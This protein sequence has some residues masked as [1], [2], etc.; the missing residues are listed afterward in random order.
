MS[1]AVEVRGDPND[2]RALPH[3]AERRHGIFRYRDDDNTASVQ[4][5]QRTVGEPMP[6]RTA[7]PGN[8]KPALA[9]DGTKNATRY[10][11]ELIVEVASARGNAGWKLKSGI[12]RK[13]PPCGGNDEVLAARIRAGNDNEKSLYLAAPTHNGGHNITLIWH[14]APCPPA[15]TTGATQNVRSSG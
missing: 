6:L 5:Q 1:N 12:L 8:R 15:P 4:C 11:H 9:F 2:D 7:L 10:R 14:S 3:P 13:T